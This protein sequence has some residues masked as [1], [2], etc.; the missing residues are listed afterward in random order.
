MTCVQHTPVE[1]G[2]RMECSWVSIIRCSP[3]LTP[4]VSRVL[5]DTVSRALLDLVF[6]KP[7]VIPSCI[8]P[9]HPITRTSRHV[10]GAEVRLEKLFFFRCHQ[11]LTRHVTRRATDGACFVRSA[12]SAG[13]SK[14]Q[15]SRIF[16]VGI[17]AWDIP[18]PPVESVCSSREA[19]EVHAS[20][21]SCRNYDL[22][23]RE[24]EAK[25]M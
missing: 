14:T 22:L 24:S 11:N 13:P 3:E 2:L 20:T 5:L 19:E 4:T 7:F 16:F 18:P 15:R 9:T 23:L 12:M 21:H 25:N 6:V 17:D 8:P 1:L 10:I